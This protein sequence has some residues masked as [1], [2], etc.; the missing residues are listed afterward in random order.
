MQCQ[1]STTA[2]LKFK[3]GEVISSHLL[4]SMLLLIHVNPT[5]VG[6]LIHMGL[7]PDT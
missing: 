4:L 2:P 5:N 1:A 7:L 6:K 3:N